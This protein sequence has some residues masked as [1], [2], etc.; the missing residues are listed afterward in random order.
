MIHLKHLKE[1]GGGS[2]K[3]VMACDGL[4][5]YMPTH[6]LTDKIDEVTCVHCFYLWH[7]ADK[8]VCCGGRGPRNEEEKN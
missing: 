4:E 8:V 5:N 2:Y 3:D 1:L 6:S 7:H